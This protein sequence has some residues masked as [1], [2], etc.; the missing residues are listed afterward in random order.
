MEHSMTKYMKR[1]DDCLLLAEHA[2]DESSRRRY[3]RMSDAWLALAEEQR[4][5]EEQ[6][7]AIGAVVVKDL[8]A[9]QAAQ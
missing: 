8:A 2:V 7:T 6:G 5:L 1:A 3:L 9:S 4:W